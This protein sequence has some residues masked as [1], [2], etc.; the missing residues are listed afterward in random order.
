MSDDLTGANA[1]AS[2]TASYCRSAT[3]NVEIFNQ[4][5]DVMDDFQCVSLNTDTRNSTPQLAAA[6][7]SR[8]ALEVKRTG[9]I[10]AKRIDSTLRGNIEAEL[11]AIKEVLNKPFIIT[12]TIPEYGRFTRGGSTIA[13]ADRLSFR[14]V[15]KS[16]NGAYVSIND[17][18]QINKL[19][20]QYDVIVVDSSSYEDLD[21]IARTATEQGLIPVDPGP[22]CSMYGKRA[23]GL[24]ERPVKIRPVSSLV[25]IIGTRES[26]T[27]S[28]VEELKR[29]GFVILRLGNY[30]AGFDNEVS[31]VLF[32][33]LTERNRVDSAF[34]NFVSKYDAAVVSG[35]DTANLILKLAGGV[36]IENF[37]SPMPLVGIGKV[38]G[39]VLDGKIFVTKGGRVGTKETLIK[40]ASF[41]TGGGIY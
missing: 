40:L 5:T 20:R 7:V 17:L 11:M 28:Q 16:L 13:G 29:R 6:T 34:I 12:D 37:S 15:F 24:R 8:I 22:L 35:G 26:A 30:M 39:G 3:F 2:M 32:D 41:L 38:H 19:V 21:V 9:A 23:L 25:F 36:F 1:V 27:L 33:Y 14:N 31:V 18:N 10:L 4:V